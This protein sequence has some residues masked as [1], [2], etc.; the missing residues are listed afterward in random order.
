MKQ[1]TIIDVA[2]GILMGQQ[3]CAQAEAF[4]VLAATARARSMHISELAAL[5]VKDVNGGS[6][7]TH[8]DA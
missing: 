4:S 5:V 8:F 6:V 1:R 7:S 3:R 2:V